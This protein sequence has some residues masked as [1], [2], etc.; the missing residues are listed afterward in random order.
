MPV[1][2]QTEQ[3]QLTLVE[4][5]KEI[6]NLQKNVAPHNKQLRTHLGYVSDAHIRD[7]Y[8]WSPLI[9]KSIDSYDCIENLIKEDY[10]S[11][12]RGALYEYEQ[13]SARIQR[14]YDSD[15]KGDSL[16]EREKKGLGSMSELLKKQRELLRHK[17]TIK[18][19][20]KAQICVSDPVVTIAGEVKSAYGCVTNSH[21]NAKSS[22]DLERV[23]LLKDL[24][25]TK[26]YSS[27]LKDAQYLDNKI[28]E[29]S[30]TGL[31]YVRD[32][33]LT[34]AAYIWHATFYNHRE[35]R[36]YSLVLGKMS[37][38]K[39]DHLFRRI[40]NGVAP[41]YRCDIELR[42]GLRDGVPRKKVH[43]Q[44]SVVIDRCRKSFE[45]EFEQLIPPVRER[46]Y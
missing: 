43:N 24:I 30:K 12:V 18:A 45:N 5:I 17:A 4:R 3:T 38:H 9:G 13:I 29:F 21:S 23:A 7:A 14:H 46:H 10:E 33:L 22:V 25:D 1:K 27:A 6:D 15:I 34:Y 41:T 16:E 31:R 19:K 8:C 44:D 2:T 32:N 11:R 36:S 42:W 28:K 40:L 20:T 35:A 37:P 26:K 39:L